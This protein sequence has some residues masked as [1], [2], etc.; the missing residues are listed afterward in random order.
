MRNCS[1]SNAAAPSRTGTAVTEHGNLGSLS[2]I[3]LG[4][5]T[6]IIGC[7]THPCGSGHGPAGRA[8]ESPSRQIADFSQVAELSLESRLRD[9]PARL[10]QHWSQSARRML[11][12]GSAVT[13]DSCH[14]SSGGVSETLRAAP[15]VTAFG[16]GTVTT[17]AGAAARQDGRID[18]SRRSR[19]L[20]PVTNSCAP[21]SHYSSS[22]RDD[23]SSRQL[24]SQRVEQPWFAS[25]TV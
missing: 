5:H 8:A 18:Q 7:G 1:N 24:E 20:F 16:P 9:S 11:L 25:F 3:I 17:L 2:L 23:R 14:R 6:C 22:R 19:R 15:T 10:R 4:L 21:R 13:R 12:D